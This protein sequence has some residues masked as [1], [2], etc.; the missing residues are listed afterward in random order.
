MNITEFPDEI[1]VIILSSGFTYPLVRICK[2]WYNMIFSVL[3]SHIIKASR[4][5]C[6]MAY[7]IQMAIRKGRVD[8]L[9]TYK[10]RVNNWSNFKLSPEQPETALF[11]IKLNHIMIYNYDF[12]YLH[13]SEKYDELSNYL[14]FDCAHKWHIIRLTPKI[15]VHFQSEYPTMSLILRNTNVNPNEL[16]RFLHENRPDLLNRLLYSIN[17]LQ[18]QLVI[19]LYNNIN[20]LKITDE[21]IIQL[22]RLC[23]YR[24]LDLNDIIYKLNPKLIQYSE[25]YFI[26][27]ALTEKEFLSSLNFEQI[28]VY[29]DARYLS[30]EYFGIVNNIRLNIRDIYSI[31]IVFEKR[32]DLI[33]LQIT[34]DLLGL[35]HEKPCIAHKS[36]AIMCKFLM[37]NV[38]KID[39]NELAGFSMITEIPE[40]DKKQFLMKYRNE[41]YGNFKINY[42]DWRFLLD[43]IPEC[44]GEIYNIT[45]TN[46]SN[47]CVICER[48]QFTCSNGYADRIIK[49]NPSIMIKIQDPNPSLSGYGRMICSLKND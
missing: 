44:Y 4:N 11:V 46:T 34:I 42:T 10:S 41:I 8:L 13:T 32:Q 12:S 6:L 2:K 48:G 19:Y 38:C 45:Q 39:P 1:V 43:N 16:F 20:S 22:T 37:K 3:S 36:S 18:D 7:I 40:I 28:S 21:D 26:Y 23:I 31:L 49:M 17:E 35:L 30:V 24:G 25:L 9:E 15:F 29:N 27:R 14:Y 47:F 5:N 33:N